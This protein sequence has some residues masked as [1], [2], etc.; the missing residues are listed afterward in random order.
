MVIF[1][2]RPTG[3][4]N[5]ARTGTWYPTL[6]HS[7]HTGRTSY[8]PILLMPESEKSQ[9]YK[10]LAES[11]GNQTP[12]PPRAMPMVY[13]FGYHAQWEQ[14]VGGNPL[15]DIF[16][17][18]GCTVSL[19]PTLVLATVL[20]WYLG[21]E[22]LYWTVATT[23]IICTVNVHLFLPPEVEGRFLVETLYYAFSTNK[24]AQWITD[25][26]SSSQW[27]D[28]YPLDTALSWLFSSTAPL[29]KP[30]CQ[31]LDLISCQ[32]HYPVHEPA[33]HFPILKIS[34]V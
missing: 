18:E 8:F 2:C 10:S 5:A 1:E 22:I 23:L 25:S 29:G 31:I 12:N 21:V 30:G 16:H 20:R 28:R 4:N 34:T 19:V 33:S 17:K 7:P 11:P 26:I 3:K 15:W 32:S 6:S 9:F 14:V 24:A 27:K 13:H